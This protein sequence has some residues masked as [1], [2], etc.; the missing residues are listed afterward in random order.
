M[1]SVFQNAFY[2]GNN[3]NTIIYGVELTV[4]ILTIQ[5]IRRRPRPSSKDKLL[6]VFS[7]IL[8]LLNT[9]FVATESVF[10]EEM[11]VVNANYPGGSDAYLEDFASVWYQ[12]FGTAASIVLNLFSDA[13][14]IY[15]CYII[16]ADVRLVLFPTVLYLATFALGIAQL[17]A[18]G[19]PHSN[20]F[21]GLAQKLG[22]AY[23]S[24]IIS[25][26]IILT[27]LICGRILY[28]ARRSERGSARA[29]AYT[30]SAAITIESALPCTLL[31]I[32]YLVTFARGDDVSIFFLSIYVMSTC[33]APQ[34]IILRVV[35]G[36]AWTL[37]TTEAIMTGS[38]TGG[39]DADR[40]GT[41]SATLTVDTGAEYAKSA[42]EKV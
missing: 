19:M 38:S 2:I 7:T 25:L 24:S 8:L 22:T 30:G 17:V 16:W 13:L 26:E 41:G 35:S 33:L 39:R 20:Y 1:S 29:L 34:M 6:V 21:A 40:M 11:W 37:D 31:G 10:G 12:T 32:A 4:Y 9:I 28:V 36:R 3:F 27:A 14:M 42:L 15:R 5:A 18:S 23:T